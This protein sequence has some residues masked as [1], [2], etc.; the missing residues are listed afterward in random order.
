MYKAN[1]KSYSSLAWYEIT[2][3]PSSQKKYDWVKPDIEITSLPSTQKYD[4]VEPD[5]EIQTLS[6]SG[7]I[8]SHF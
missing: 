6:L 2:T 5:N 8:Q 7:L 1:H 3:L 4:W